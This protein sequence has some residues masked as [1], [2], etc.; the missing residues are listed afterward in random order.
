MRTVALWVTFLI[1]LLPFN[2]SYADSFTITG[3]TWEA[4]QLFSDTIIRFNGVSPAGASLA[5]SLFDDQGPI[6]PFGVSANG[7]PFSFSTQFSGGS[8]SLTVDGR[9][10]PSGLPFPSFG[11]F[12]LTG[13]AIAPAAAPSAFI[14]SVSGFAS[15]AGTLFLCSDLSCDDRTVHTV[16]GAGSANLEMANFGGSVLETRRLEVTFAPLSTSTVPEP[17][18]L[19][20]LGSGLGGLAAWRVARGRSATFR[21][22]FGEHCSL[23]EES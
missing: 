16:T 13:T 19:V 21:N 4:R 22:A 17:G 7:L 23:A 2:M 10:F 6:T 5:V 12:Q 8:G 15:V 11:T 1:G 20:L 9:T 14:T 3:G 18:T